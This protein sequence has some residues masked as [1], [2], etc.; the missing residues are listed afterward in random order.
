[1]ANIP[2]DQRTDIRFGGSFSSS[3][4]Q[5]TVEGIPVKATGNSEGIWVGFKNRLSDD[6]VANPFFGGSLSYRSANVRMAN[7]NNPADYFEIDD[8][9]FGWG[10]SVGCDVNASEKM[11]IRLGFGIGRSFDADSDVDLDP[12]GFL[13]SAVWLTDQFF[14]DFGAHFDVDD[15]VSF[16]GGA[17]YSF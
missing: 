6:P 7:P 9:W 3:S 1:M 4:K 11:S 15:D 10:L 8:D 13:S 5:S 17:S 12:G 16:G 2:I 14:I